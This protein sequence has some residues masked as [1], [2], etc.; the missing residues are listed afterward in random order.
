M[1]GAAGSKATAWKEAR[2]IRK[3]LVTLHKGQTL[4]S[5]RMFR[6]LTK[7]EEILE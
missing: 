6:M 5:Y 1:T 2:N 7:K 3:R 4:F